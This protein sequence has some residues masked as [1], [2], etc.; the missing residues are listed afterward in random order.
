MR[1]RTSDR[2]SGL[3]GIYALDAGIEHALAGYVI[4]LGGAPELFR[5]VA[6]C[7]YWTVRFAVAVWFLYV[8]LTVKLP[9]F[10][11]T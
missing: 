3:R 10:V 7:S 8:K 4:D 11:P 6:G 2:P 5:S 9:P 1:Y